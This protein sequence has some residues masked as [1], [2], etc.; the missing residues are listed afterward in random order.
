MARDIAFNRGTAPRSV[1]SAVLSRTL[2]ARGE[3]G[4]LGPDPIC[5]RH[6]DGTVEPSMVQ[7]ACCCGAAT[8]SGVL[9]FRGRRH[10]SR[11]SGTGHGGIDVASAEAGG[12]IHNLR[13]SP[14]FP[15]ARAGGTGMTGRRQR[16]AGEPG[17][18]GH[19]PRRPAEGAGA[20]ARRRCAG[21]G[22]GTAGRAEA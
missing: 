11:I 6:S 22:A 12:E 18:R 21:D 16:P 9:D 5:G 3:D 8:G 13:E 2:A 10:R 17:R 4:R 7:A 19:A 15:G 14:R 20:V 1:G